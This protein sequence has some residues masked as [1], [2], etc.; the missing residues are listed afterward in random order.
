MNIQ[1]I[2]KEPSKMEIYEIMDSI[3]TEMEENFEMNL[4]ETNDDVITSICAYHFDR[5]VGMG[6]VIKEENTLYIQD[7]IIKP[8]YKGEEIE[9]NIIVNLFKQINE[10]KR[11]NSSIQRCLQIEESEE[12]F[13]N[14]FSFLTKEKQELGA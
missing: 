3:Q 14:R 6:R 4:F 7:I 5:I 13:F 1:Y 10:L 12:N 11:F 2:N 8:E 9:N